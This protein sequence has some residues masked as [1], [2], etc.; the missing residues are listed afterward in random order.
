MDTNGPLSPA[1]QK[2]AE[3]AAAEA[4]S[5]TIQ[6][7]TLYAIGVLVTI[8]RT[9]ARIKAVGIRE[10]TADDIFI[11]V[12]ALLYTGQTVL[13]YSVGSVAHGL[14]NNGMT[15]AQRLALTPDNPEFHMRVVGSKIQLAGWSVYSSLMLFL[16]LSVLVFYIRLTQGLG[17]RYRLQIWT[18]F[19][20]VIGTFI[21]SIAVILLSCL[22]L[23]RNWQ[24]Y[25]NPGNHCQ[26]A[27]SQTIVWTSFAA[28]ASTDLYLILIPLPMLW[29]SS[30]K[31]IKKIASSIVLGAGIFVLVS[32]TLK[33]VFVTVDPVNGAQQAGEWGT[34]E[35]FVAVFTTNL[36]MIFP[37]FKVWLRPMFGSA[38]RST[39]KAYM[40]HDGSQTIGG[41]GTSRTGKRNTRGPSSSKQLTSNLSTN[42]SQEH[43]VQQQDI[44]LQS[45]AVSGGGDLPLNTRGAYK[46]NVV[47]VSTEVDMVNE[48]ASTSGDD[49]R[50]R[51]YENW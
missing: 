35:A 6:L 17:R 12:A 26:P 2:A 18:G 7:W 49:K 13:G 48:P 27:I 20:L 36:P 50:G 3:A 34:R 24:I 15:D 42:D 47:Y 38:L 5:F 8:L 22:P 28:S 51:G 39:Q 1:A 23:Q 43:M 37:L 19:F 11:W 45:F 32:A 31:L 33:T 40:I 9:Y 21:A 14:A 25:P 16:K 10:L 4:R 44:P 29:G 41:G 30:L 46:P